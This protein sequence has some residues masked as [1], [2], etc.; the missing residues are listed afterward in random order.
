MVLDWDRRIAIAGANG[1][2][3]APT[4]QPTATGG[5][6]G[7][8]S[9][10]LPSGSVTYQRIDVTI[11]ATGALSGTGQG[12]ATYVPPSSDVGST[13]MVTMALAGVP[14]AEPPTFTANLGAAQIDP[15]TSITV[16]AS[17][18]LPP[19]S[20]LAIVDLRGDRV[21][22]PAAGTSTTAA[23][24]FVTSAFRMWRYSDQYT[25]LVGGI[26]DFAGNMSSPGGAIV[27]TTGAPPPLAAEDG[28]ESATGTTFA[29]A[30]VLAGSGAPTITGTRS[31]YIPP[32]PSAFPPGR[33]DI[34]QLGL[35][36]AVDP[37]DTVVRF[38]YRSVNQSPTSASPGFLLG[39]EGGQ[40]AYAYLAADSGL[41]TTETIG[42]ESVS[43][44][45]VTTA[46]IVLPA[47]AASAG[48]VT[49]L[50]RIS[51]CCGGLP[52]PPVPGLIIDDLRAE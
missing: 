44:G 47:G 31:L 50:R 29:G 16:A 20:R 12:Y 25:I 3:S 37:T 42:Q 35:R 15:F 14:D 41:S 45:P 39:A 40:V 43:L 30:Q 18:P 22:L 19:D 21:D 6:I 13:S 17:E 26:V 32:L 10:S 36:L 48:A 23:F 51:A 34:T 9:L 52:S 33:G 1:S 8:L 7:Q 38:A 28:F 4:F 24:S 49:L 2:G 46:E 27:F 5:S 11:G